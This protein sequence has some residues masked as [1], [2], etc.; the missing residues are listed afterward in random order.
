M[1]KRAPPVEIIHRPKLVLEGL[2]LPFV[3]ALILFVI[4]IGATL[5]FEGGIY[6]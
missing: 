5:Y 2:W 4:P 6:D 3:V 1:V